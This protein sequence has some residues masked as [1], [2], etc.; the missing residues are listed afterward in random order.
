MSSERRIFHVLLKPEE[1][2]ARLMEY[3]KPG[4][5]GVEEVELHR[6]YGRILAEDVYSKVD[7]PPFTRSTVDGYA[8][9]SLDLSHASEVAPRKLRVVGS[10]KVGEWPRVEVKHGEAVEIDTGAPLPPGADSVVMIEYT[11]R[12]GEEV[13]VYKSVAPGENTAKIGSDV[14]LGDLVLRKC[15]RLGER[16]IAVLAAVGRR[17]VRVFKKPRVAV[18]STGV[19]LIEPGSA[20]SPGK[21]YDVNTYS[22]TAGLLE[23]GAEPNVVGIV[24][25]SFEA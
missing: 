4:A 20:L 16:E 19:E 13:L 6:A 17:G 15:T 14:S 8:V 1:A 3:V 7:Y 12:V 11:K 18:I 24:E 9:R 21:V 10:I 2:L 22:V 5:W 25:D 23:V